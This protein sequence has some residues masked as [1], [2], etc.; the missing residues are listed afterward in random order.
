MDFNLHFAD[1]YRAT[2]GGLTMDANLVIVF[3][4]LL[5]LVEGAAIAFLLGH[6]DALK[7]NGQTSNT[8]DKEG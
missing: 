4:T 8:P 6:I 5:A 2:E 3:A 1:F 7:A